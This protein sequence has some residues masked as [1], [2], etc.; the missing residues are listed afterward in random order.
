MNKSKKLNFDLNLSNEKDARFEF[1]FKKKDAKIKKK[2]VKNRQRP[3]EWKGT[4][5]NS[6]L[7]SKSRSGSDTKS[8]SSAG[9]STRTR[10]SS[11]DR[12]STN[13]ETSRSGATFV[14]YSG[15][16]DSVALESG[17]FK[18]TLKPQTIPVP[19]V[20]KRNP[21]Q[22]L[23]E[24]DVLN[25]EKELKSL[26]KKLKI[27]NGKL[28]EKFKE[29]GLEYLLGFQS[30]SAEINFEHPMEFDSSQGEEIAESSQDD[31]MNIDMSESNSSDNGED[32]AE[33]TS[34]DEDMNI[35]M[36]ESNSSDMQDSSEMDDLKES[37]T[38]NE[39]KLE[40]SLSENADLQPTLKQKT[41]STS[42]IYG[43]NTY[44]PPHLRK[45]IEQD[46]KLRKILQGHINRLAN[47]NMDS[48]VGFTMDLA[49]NYS[50]NEMN[51]TITNIVVSSIA[52]SS[53][54]LDGFCGTFGCYLSCLYNLMGTEF[55][56][57]LIQQVCSLFCQ[58]YEQRIQNGDSDYG[59]GDKKCTNLGL[60][61]AYLYSLGVT[62]HVLVYDLI[63]KC[64]GNLHEVDLEILKRF[65]TVCGS[66][67]RKDDP[68]AL[69]EIVILLEQSMLTKE[70]TPRMKYL[71]ESIAELKNSKKRFAIID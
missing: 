20:E 10:S 4:K 12:Q 67:L 36:S 45:P 24:Q 19:R 59:V 54:L 71:A 27:K 44:V 18:K 40:S 49:R 58:E 28:N 64:I 57:H 37:E 66:Q 35:D 9:S 33:S 46:D 30:D 42:D 21:L 23:V 11:S 47:Q 41:N 5:S 3:R 38:L 63:K 15:S 56:A 52:D 1:R 22:D 7:D 53:N 70:V 26:E 6:G 34:Q 39:S 31:E 69:K 32:I 2:L 65:L 62:S 43:Q 17:Q 60:L 50:R 61:I 55:G 16:K 25:E 48:I 14:K 13:P 51:T 8:R 68:S 29:D